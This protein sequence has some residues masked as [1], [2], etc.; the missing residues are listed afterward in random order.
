M[1]ALKFLRQNPPA[2]ISGEEV[3]VIL[4]WATKNWDRKALHGVTTITHNA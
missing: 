3:A 1:Q 2:E 4:E